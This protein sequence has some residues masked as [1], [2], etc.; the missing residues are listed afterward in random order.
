M[1]IDGLDT[2]HNVDGRNIQNSVRS[3]FLPHLISLLN[4]LSDTFSFLSIVSNRENILVL[5]IFFEALNYETIEQKKAYEV[6]GLLGEICHQSNHRFHS[7]FCAH[8]LCLCLE[9]RRIYFFS[10]YKRH[11]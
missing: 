1:L 10:A 9:I 5:D 4:P 11:K 8:S 7:Y 2:S 6:A 3:F